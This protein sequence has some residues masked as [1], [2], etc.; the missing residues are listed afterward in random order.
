M[1]PYQIR[2]GDRSLTTDQKRAD[3]KPNPQPRRRTPSR[4]TVLHRAPRQARPRDQSPPRPSRAG[5][6]PG[7]GWYNADVFGS[8]GSHKCAVRLSLPGQTRTAPGKA[9]SHLGIHPYTN[10]CENIGPRRRGIRRGLI[11][12]DPRPKGARA[13]RVQG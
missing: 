9:Q 10:A 5:W 13:A 4:A 3:S 6:A 8:S 12:L 2:L 7:L 11:F 1:A